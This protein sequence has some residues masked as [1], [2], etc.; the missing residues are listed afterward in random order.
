[1]DGTDACVGMTVQFRYGFGDQ[2]VAGLITAVGS[3][4]VTVHAWHPNQSQPDIRTGVMH[5]SNSAAMDNIAR[6]DD[7]GIWDYVE[8]QPPEEVDKLVAIKESKTTNE[9]PPG[10]VKRR[11]TQDEP[12]ETAEVS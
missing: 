2:P 7:S 9:K 10:M 11:K 12:A 8:R 6:N 3:D 5:S 1:M 4:R